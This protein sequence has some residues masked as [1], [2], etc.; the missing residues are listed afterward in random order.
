M[1]I[2]AGKVIKVFINHQHQKGRYYI[3]LI[4]FKQGKQKIKYKSFNFMFISAGNIEF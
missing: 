1:V 2:K 4:I 3:Y